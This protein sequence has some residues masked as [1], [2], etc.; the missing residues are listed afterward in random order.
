MYYWYLPLPYQ[1]LWYLV[2][3][4]S[5]LQ[6]CIF[7]FLDTTEEKVDREKRFKE[8]GNKENS[9]KPCANYLLKFIENCLLINLVSWLKILHTV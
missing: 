5:G 8:R 1:F 4:K 3:L 6:I 7:H 2:W 9:C